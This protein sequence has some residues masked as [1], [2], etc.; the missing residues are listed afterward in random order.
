MGIAL[1]F[2]LDDTLMV[3]EQA[4]ADAFAATAQVAAA[5]HEIDAARLAVDARSRARELWYAAATHDYCIRIGIS[6]WE[7]LW[8]RFEGEGDEIRALSDW[9]P[10]YRQEA[11]RLA[12]ADQEIDDSRL[13]EELAECFGVERRARHEVFVDAA[14]SLG[15][16]SGSHRLGLLTNGAAC[17]QREKLAASGLGDHFE[18][19][20]VSADLGVAKPD[21]AAFE[22]ILEQLDVDRADAVM[23]GDSIVKDVDGALAA[24]L[25][26][27]WVNRTGQPAPADRPDLV[28]ISTLSDLPSVL[29]E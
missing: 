28:E 18:V 26:A 10:S 1:L 9:S 6:S 25:R 8:C 7:G 27:V 22:H 14:E 3:E 13:A 16:L 21:A 19:V 23:I 2:D 4:A 15:L 29:G 12:L 11:W 24:G 20:V 5:Q 17:L